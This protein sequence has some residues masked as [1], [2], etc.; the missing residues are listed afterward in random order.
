[1][2]SVPADVALEGIAEPVAA[3][4]DGEHHIIQEE[5]AAV[6]APVDPD[7]LPFLVDDLKGVAWAYGGRLD[8]V[9]RPWEVLQGLE[10]VVGLRG[11]HRA[12]V[13]G[14]VLPLLVVAVSVCGVLAAVVRGEGSVGRQAFVPE[15]AMALLRILRVAVRHVGAGQRNGV[16]AADDWH[17]FG[18]GRWRRLHERA[19]GFGPKVGDGVVYGL[20]HH[21]ALHDVAFLLVHET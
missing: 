3:H 21:A 9:I 2:A 15:V 13:E 6:V 8:D 1:M 11:D 7:G 14:R 5:D 18:G 10:A 12:L 4:V 19:Q 20:V 16:Q 17:H